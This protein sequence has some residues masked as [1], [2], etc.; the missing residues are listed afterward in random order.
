MARS[1][2]TTLR[3]D[4]GITDGGPATGPARTG[5]RDEHDD[6]EAAD[7]PVVVVDEKIVAGGVRQGV[8]AFLVALAPAPL[9]VVFAGVFAAVFETPFL[10]HRSWPQDA[11]QQ[12]PRAQGAPG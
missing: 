10:R 3:Q 6:R 12:H 5:Q 11:G 4:R 2:P 9:T 1:L 8:P 7:G